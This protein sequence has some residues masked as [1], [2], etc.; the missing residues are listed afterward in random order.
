MWMDTK[1]C[2]FCFVF[3]QE[4]ITGPWKMQ[5]NEVHWKH[6]WKKV[7]YAQNSLKKVKYIHEGENSFKKFKIKYLCISN[8]GQT[9]KRCKIWTL[10]TLMR[11]LIH[12]ISKNKNGAQKYLF[13]DMMSHDRKV[14]GGALL[15]VAYSKIIWDRNHCS[16][17]SGERQVFIQQ[18]PLVCDWIKLVNSI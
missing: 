17:F 16:I 1:M 18:I 11:E 3:G 12:R 8:K 14:C 10:I 2:L 4:K 7:K 6:G 9:S 13:E 15:L 5:K